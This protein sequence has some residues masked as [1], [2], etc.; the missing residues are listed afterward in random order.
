MTLRID[1]KQDDIHYNDIRQKSRTSF[2]IMTH[3][4]MKFS[5]MTLSIITVLIMNDIQI[6]TLLIMNG[7]YK[8][9]LSITFRIFDSKQKVALH[10]DNQHNGIWHSR[11]NWDTQYNR[12]FVAECL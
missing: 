3:R 1:T 10:N 7:I 5:Q 11:F 8:M 9:T 12:N 2:S 6:M 4:I